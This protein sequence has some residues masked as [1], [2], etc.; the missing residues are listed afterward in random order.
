M[1]AIKETNFFVAVGG[2]VDLFLTME[3]KARL[4]ATSV[5][6]PSE[7]VK[8]F[9]SASGK[10]VGEVSPSYLY[11]RLAPQRIAASLPNV[12]LI[13]LLRD[14]VERA[15]SAYMRRP[16]AVVD[17]EEFVRVAEHE[18]MSVERGE[19]TST[20]PLIR[21]GLYA[22]GVRRY[23]DLFPRSQLWFHIYEEFWSD[24]TDGLSNL[25]GFLGVG[26]RTFVGGSAMNKSGIPRSRAMDRVL[27]SGARLKK[28][29]KQHLPPALL[30][31]LIRSRQ[32]LEDRNL[33]SPPTLPD[34]VRTYLLD[35]YFSAD[36][37]RLESILGRSLTPWTRV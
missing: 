33:A 13:G 3:A 12:K 8:L 11:S 9:E 22:D 28:I 17:P 31:P 29:A 25:L 24:P 19:P 6:D 2:E 32:W 4:V 23:F 5:S 15:Y 27:R 35:R 34:Q 7:Y 30:T 26:S 18:E 14:P 21:G 36:I 10:A 16:S 37:E 1:A 20:L